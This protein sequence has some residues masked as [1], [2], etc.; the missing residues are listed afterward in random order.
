MRLIKIIPVLLLLLSST[1]IKAQANPT[2]EIVLSKPTA[3]A[4]E[5]VRADV[6]IRNGVNIGGS[7]IG[8]TVDETCLRITNRTAGTYVP[9]DAANGG[10]SP[11]SELHDHDTR[12]S[13]AITDRTK[14]ANGDGV[15]YSVDLQ[16]ICENGIAPLTIVFGELSAY[17]DPTAAQIEFIAYTMSATTV[18]IIN[19]QLVVGTAQLPPPTV[20]SPQ[21]G[22]TPNSGAAT[23]TNQQPASIPTPEAAQTPIIPIALV[24][25]TVIGILG[26]I[27]AFIILR[28][29]NTDEDDS[30]EE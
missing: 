2:I 27:V 29:R 7:D 15:F 30:V 1:F 14:L 20:A 3:N 22:T 21:T 10:F 5:T 11:F 12:F 18:N 25:L 28:R 23:G 16:V 6:Y 9:S 24:C 26:I 8:I 17:K 19:T 13:A 4:G